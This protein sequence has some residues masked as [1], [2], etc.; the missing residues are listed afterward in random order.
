MIKA[1]I[2][3]LEAPILILV[4]LVNGIRF[5]DKFTETLILDFKSLLEYREEG[6]QRNRFFG[7][8]RLISR[9]AFA[10]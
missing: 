9:W 8:S 6:I 5:F 4:P 2:L 3:F 1:L 7:C 10:L